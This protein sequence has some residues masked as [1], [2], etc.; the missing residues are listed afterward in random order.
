[1]QLGEGSKRRSLIKEYCELSDWLLTLSRTLC[2]KLKQHDINS[3]S[4]FNPTIPSGLVPHKSV[5]I[6]I[7]VS[8]ENKYDHTV[9]E[10]LTAAK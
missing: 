2:D 7:N 1:M 9:A 3:T 5:P 8:K 10:P 6:I 4:M